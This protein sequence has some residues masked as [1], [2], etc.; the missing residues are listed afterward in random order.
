MSTSSASGE[1]GRKPVRNISGSRFIAYLRRIKVGA[2]LIATVAGTISK[3]VIRKQLVAE[4][5]D[6][7]A[8]AG[9]LVAMTALAVLPLY[10]HAHLRSRKTL[11]IVL[12]FSLA[13]IIGVR[14]SLVE[15]LPV[16]G[17][18]HRYLVGPLLTAEGKEM[19]RNCLQGTDTT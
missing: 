9:V 8:D 18:T 6:W 1:V 2:L 5:L 15:E 4:Q 7:L 11:T 13:V 14:A 12:I 17:T 3:L 19:E 16:R 10:S